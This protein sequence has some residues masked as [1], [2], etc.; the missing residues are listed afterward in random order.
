MKGDSFYDNFLQIISDKYPRKADL[1]NR[2]LDIL[3][4]SKEALYRRL[5]GEVPFSFQEIGLIS[6]KLGISLDSIVGIT[7]TKSRPFHL[8]LTNYAQPERTD[9]VMIEEFLTIL[10]EIK[11]DPDSEMG[12]ATKIFPDALHLKFEYLT[13][14]YLFKWLC[15]FDNKKK[16]IL[17]SDVTQTGRILEL[18]EEKRRAYGHFKKTDY[19]FDKMIFQNFVDDINYFADVNIISTDDLKLLKK[20][21]LH[22]V[23]YLEEIAYKGEN[24][25]GNKINIYISNINFETGFSYIYSEKYKLSLIR[26]FTL[27]DIISLDEL[28]MENTKKWT[29]SLLRSSTQI[30]E[31]GEIQRRNF[32][33]EQRKIIDAI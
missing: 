1:S 14:F 22:F 28:T 5:R 32:F 2:L 6:G 30:S 16:T 11:K 4:I 13:R 23:G 19:I 25:F 33:N 9:Y 31:S 26:S 29:Y 18:L 8:K 12:I 21:L 27:Y 7:S 15:Q 17:Y 24:E 20:D 3:P 10:N